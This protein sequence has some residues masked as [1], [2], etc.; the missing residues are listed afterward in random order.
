MSEHEEPIRYDMGVVRGFALSAL[1]WGAVGMTVGLVIAIQLAWP[2]ANW[3]I[4]HFG[5]LRPVHTN[6]VIF[7]FTLGV[8]FAGSYYAIQRLCR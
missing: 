7:G 3:G 4:L 1:L 6:A 8:V 2:E 5:R